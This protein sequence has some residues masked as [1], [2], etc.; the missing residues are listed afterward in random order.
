[1][2]FSSYKNWKLKVKLWWIGA[3]EGR[4]RAF[5][6]QCIL[7][8]EIFFN[9]CVLSQCMVYWI[10]FQ[11]ISTFTYQKTLLHA[12]FCLFLKSSKPFS[13][14]LMEF[15]S[16]EFYETFETAVLESNCEWQLV[17][18]RSHRKCSIKNRCSLKFCK[19]H[20]KTP[21]LESLFW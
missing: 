14:S 21:V 15:F 5:F 2:C 1:M 16:W 4:K 20:R 8:E 11:N 17:Y 12:L 6:V 18:R 19:I 3:R 7:S 9:I 13:A 10:H